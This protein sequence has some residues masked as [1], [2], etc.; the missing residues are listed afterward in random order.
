MG[1]V[2]SVCLFITFLSYIVISVHGQATARPGLGSGTRVGFYSTTCPTAETIVRNAVTAGFNSNPRIAPGILRMHFH[3]C[4]V[5][6]C[7]GSILISGANTEQT[8]GPNVNLPAC[9]GV[10]SCADILALAARD[11]VVLTRGISWQVPTGRRDGRVSL[12]SNA[13]NLPGAR[14]SVAVQQEKFSAVRLSTRELVVL[15]GGHTIGQAG[16]GAFRNRL[17]NGTAGPADPTIDPTFLAQLQTQCPQNGGNTVRVDLDTG[18]GTT[19]DTSYYNNLSRGRGVLQSD[20]VLWS[21]P[22]TRPIVQ[23]LMSPRSTFN[24]EFARAMVRMSNIGVLTGANGEIRRIC[25]AIN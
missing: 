24:A 12:A 10:V 19:F 25:S 22:A 6:G 11:S 4:F 3:D 21:D 17:F 5:L 13:N 9:P 23:Q 16:C 8:A 18:S 14:D 7:D 1:L 2:R 20:Q 15:V